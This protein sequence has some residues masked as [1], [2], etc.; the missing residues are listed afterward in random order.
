MELPYNDRHAMAMTCFN[1]FNK[2]I[3]LVLLREY[4]ICN[5]VDISPNS[6]DSWYGLLVCIMSDHDPKSHVLFWDELMYLLD[7]ALV[8]SMALHPQT[9]RI[10]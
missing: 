8:F 1:R 3:E 7:T 2:M 10:A 4:N 5:I 6:L 9:H